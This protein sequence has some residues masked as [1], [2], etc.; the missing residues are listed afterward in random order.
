[1]GR[2]YPRR[3]KGKPQS[4][5]K[6]QSKRPNVSA[7]KPNQKNNSASPKGPAPRP[8]QKNQQMVEPVAET[9][10]ESYQSDNMDDDSDKEGTIIDQ[11]VVDAVH[12][13]ILTIKFIENILW[14]TALLGSEKKFR[15]IL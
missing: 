3:N 4:T 11:N 5:P 12:K 10:P 7:G 1:M 6:S 13:N 14:I 2:K 8:Q 15:K 9:V